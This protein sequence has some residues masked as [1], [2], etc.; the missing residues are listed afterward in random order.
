MPTP[1]K[2]LGESL[3]EEG[4]LTPDQLAQA[5]QEE[6]LSGQPLRRVVVKMGFLQEEE[7]TGFLSLRLGVPRVELANY[8]IDP[9]IIE[10]IS[11]TL[12]RK[13][14]IIP[15]LKIGNRLT[16]AM[17]DPSNVFALD[18]LRIATKLIIEPAV[19]AEAEIKKAL[20]D[21]YG[22]RGTLQTLI[23]SIDKEKTGLKEGEEVDLKK[24]QG[25]VKEP[26]V[27]KLVNL[28]ILQALREGASDIHI[29]PEE[30]ALKTRF[31][32]DGM[33]HE[34]ASPP[35]HLQP[36]IISRIKI[37]AN[38]DIA[39]RRI[40]QDGR[41]HLNMEGR[42]IDLRVS[43]MPT[44]YGE[45]VVLRLL[46]VSNALLT[47]TQL[48]FS[49][50]ILDKYE[51][52]ILRPYGIILVTGP[53]GSGKTTTLYS[54]LTKINTVDKNII[55]LE[56]PVEY[57]LPGIRQ[58]QVNAQVGLTFANGLRSVLRQDPDVI[59]V[60]EIRDLETARM[61]IQAALTG[62]LVLST[63]HT[64]D[65]PGAITRMIDMKVEPF[66]VASSVIGIVAQRLVR[67]LCKDC[68]EPYD[69]SP[70]VLQ[71]I[72]L[73]KADTGF[74]RGKGCPKC[75][76]TGYKGRISLFEL[77]VPDPKIRQ[78][79]VAKASLTEIKKHAQSLGMKSLKED[80]IKRIREGLT[81]VEEVLR[82]T[83]SE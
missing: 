57:R 27:I 33:L 78:L 7:L 65:A 39:E 26:V 1:K 82:V 21:Y 20:D 81:T 34:S 52:L 55:T 40:P 61:A 2:S 6:K 53:T 42:Q 73:E 59:M 72:G 30:N 68:K 17:T 54:S 32:V 12:A 11:E 24:L 62:H 46:E 29:E 18:E 5:K 25:L 51:K 31:R 50:E 41:F 10:L 36:A 48:G 22:N 38:L 15:V 70:A 4:L 47:F 71:D 45:N 63:L 37:L 79:T 44:L 76:N 28:M 13:H 19:A 75:L 56:D 69:P 35:K 49:K 80:G 16:C 14:E 66:L 74:Y 67:T 3:V 58:T 9:Q 83:E 43:C 77:M 64:N 23:Q 8:L 60:G